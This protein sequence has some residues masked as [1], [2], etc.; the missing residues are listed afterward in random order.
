MEHHGEMA[1]ARY[2]PDLSGKRI[3]QWDMGIA[4]K[5][6]HT[7]SVLLMRGS[8][9]KAVARSMAVTGAKL[10]YDSQKR[11]VR[12]NEPRVKLALAEIKQ[13]MAVCSCVPSCV[14]HS[15]MLC[16]EWTKHISNASLISWR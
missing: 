15:A 8:L 4:E 7:E 2:E 10:F 12:G 6:S 9:P 3:K 5:N 14:L 13:L 1:N 16:D 11:E